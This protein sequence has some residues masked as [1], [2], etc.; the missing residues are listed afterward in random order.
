MEIIDVVLG[1]LLV[2]GFY[3]GFKNGLFVELASLISFFVG[4]FVAVK[5][6]YVVS[7]FLE[8]HVSWSP[9][10][11]QISAFVFTLLLVIIAIH[12]LAKIFTG[13]A[14]FAFLGWANTLAGGFFA[15]IKT[16]LLIGVV[17]S[18]FQKVNLNNMI[19]SKE[20]QESSGHINFM[21]IKQKV[22]PF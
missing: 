19:V 20:T 17:L 1:A 13:I 11:I 16:A 15:T 5:F 18:L 10:T 12:S 2:F 3:K 6:S 14:S 4:V 21:G 8:K 7:D 22:F 9:K